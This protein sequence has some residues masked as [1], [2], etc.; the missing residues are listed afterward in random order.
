MAVNLVLG[1]VHLES[2]MGIGLWTA[3]NTKR[4][5]ER[6]RGVL[7]S[8]AIRAATSVSIV[9]GTGRNHPTPAE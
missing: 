3:A 1:E 6:V 8:G 7:K 9:I 2:E 4:G 5:K